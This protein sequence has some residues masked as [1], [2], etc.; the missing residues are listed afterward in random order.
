MA[1]DPI[2]DE[3]DPEVAAALSAARHT[4]PVELAPGLLA[5]MTAAAIAGPLPLASSPRRTS[6]IGKL[7][8]A[9]VLGI[10]GALALTGGV[11]AAATGTLPDPVQQPVSNAAEHVGVH[12]PQGEHGAAVSG[13]AHDKSNDGDGNHGA[14]VSNVARDNHGH[15][16]TT[17]T[18]TG[19]GE[20][21]AVGPG[22]NGHGNANGHNKDKS[23][24]DASDNAEV[25]TTTAANTPTTVEAGDSSSD[26]TGDHS[27][28]AST[29]SSHDSQQTSGHN[30]GSDHGGK[31]SD[32]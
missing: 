28:H 20:P 27:D 19:A 29:P 2:F 30:G 6:M 17:S 8:T 9:K 22:N 15:E 3:L 31:G 14:T 25:T 4:S 12:I 13:V 26:S 7:I 16:V 5:A 18:T 11:A 10:A 21:P 1:D 23:G 32:N 24:D